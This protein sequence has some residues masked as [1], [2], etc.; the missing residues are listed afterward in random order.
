[1]RNRLNIEFKKNYRSVM[2]K[3]LLKNN[4]SEYNLNDDQNIENDENESQ[5]DMIFFDFDIFFNLK[6]P[7]ERLRYFVLYKV[8]R[9]NDLHLILKQIIKDIEDSLNSD[10]YVILKTLLTLF[11][12]NTDTI[13]SDMKIFQILFDSIQDYELSEDSAKLIILYYDKLGPIFSTQNINNLIE[14]S[15]N[16]DNKC[17]TFIWKLLVR[18]ILIYSYNL[19]I[20]YFSCMVKLFDDLKSN[21]KFILSH[22]ILAMILSDN[23]ENNQIV[24]KVFNNYEEILKYILINCANGENI[25]V[26]TTILQLIEEYDNFKY[27]SDIIEYCID[28]RVSEDIDVYI[29]QDDNDEYI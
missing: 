26:I 18:L 1:M 17:R 8:Q 3:W 24:K 29:L 2:I 9:E 4:Q 13:P 14:F 23:E 15:L 10:N 6:A 21:D 27:F 19:S 25:T 5:N 7:I 12:Y 28:L 20:D 22:I 11:S 16:G